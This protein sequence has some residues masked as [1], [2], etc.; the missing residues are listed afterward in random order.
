M[1]WSRG[2]RNEWLLLDWTAPNQAYHF[3]Y[4]QKFINARNGV[5]Y[6]IIL[7]IQAPNLWNL[8]IIFFLRCVS[9]YL[10]SAK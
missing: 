10:D 5:I 1:I 8:Q 2:E 7:D 3:E 6:L 4:L 9:S